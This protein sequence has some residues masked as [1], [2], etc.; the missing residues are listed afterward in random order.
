MGWL[1][2]PHPHDAGRNA[3]RKGRL[4][5]KKGET[6]CEEEKDKEEHHMEV[7]MIKKILSTEKN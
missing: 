1:C 4:P 6:P 5:E 7:E 3:E 2:P